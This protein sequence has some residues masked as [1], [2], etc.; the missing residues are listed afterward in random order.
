MAPVLQVLLIR[1]PLVFCSKKACKYFDQ[2][3][4]SCPFGAKCLYLHALP[5]GTR[6]EPDRPRKQLSSEG[7]V[8]VSSTYQCHEQVAPLLTS[9]MNP[10]SVRCVFVCPRPCAVHEQCPAMGLHWRAR[11]ALSATPAFLHRRHHRTEGALY[12]DVWTQ[13]GGGGAPLSYWLI[14][15]VMAAAT[16]DQPMFI[17]SF[18]FFHFFS[19]LFCTYG[20]QNLVVRCSFWA[21]HSA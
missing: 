11:T 15:G 20:C 2:G 9:L 4:G 18:F 7:N 10:C 21:E 14:G 1:S 5:D 12:A 6:P 19:N 17:S 3:R 8:R 16:C 13:H